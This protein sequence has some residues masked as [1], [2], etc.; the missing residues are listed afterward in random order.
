MVSIMKNKCSQIKTPSNNWLI[1]TILTRIKKKSN[2]KVYT[3]MPLKKKKKA[4]SHHK[5]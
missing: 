3:D 1:L 5:T 2:T 4:D